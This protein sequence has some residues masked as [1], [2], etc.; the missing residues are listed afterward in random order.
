M[1]GPADSLWTTYTGNAATSEFH[2]IP[3]PAA[4][5]HLARIWWDLEPLPY[6]V[7]SMGAIVRWTRFGDMN[8]RVNDSNHGQGF[9]WRIPV[10]ALHSR[11]LRLP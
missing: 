4:L 5:D 8:P 10:T 7:P 9:C 11:R 2:P 1:L 3:Q 6:W